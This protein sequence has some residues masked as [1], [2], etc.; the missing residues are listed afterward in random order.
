MQC[1]HALRES[2]NFIK[3]DPETLPLS[4]LCPKCTRGTEDGDP[5]RGFYSDC[6]RDPLRHFPFETNMFLPKCQAQLRW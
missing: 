4:Y 1:K 5:Y 6:C 2:S 3:R